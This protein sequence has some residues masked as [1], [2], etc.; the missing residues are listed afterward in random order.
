MT[1]E[2]NTFTFTC[3]VCGWTGASAWSEEEA[4]VECRELF[5]EVPSGEDRMLICD[6]CFYGKVIAVYLPDDYRKRP[7]A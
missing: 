6:D 1:E 7:R 4:D 5:G 3:A 2:K